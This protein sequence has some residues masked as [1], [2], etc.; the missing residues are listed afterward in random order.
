MDKNIVILGSTGS[1]GTQT[2]EVIDNL[3]NINVIALSTNERIDILETQIR[4]YKPK[5]AVVINK[6]KAN[7]L[8]ENI[9]DTSTKILVG[10]E[11][12]VFIS[13]IEEVHMMINALVGNVGL[14]PTVEAIKHKKDIALA[15]K[16]TLV[17]AGEIVMK[18][19]KK[20]DVNIYPIDSEHCAILQCIQGSNKNDIDKIIL[21][22]SGGP[23]RTYD[24]LLD[25][26]VEKALKH[27]NWIMG[28]KITIDSATLM[29]KGLEVIEA[30][31]LFDIDIENIDI[32]IHPQSIIHS[33]VQYKDNSIIAQLGVPDMRIPIQYCLTY[34]RKSKNN[35][36]KFDISKVLNLTFESPKYDLFP[37]LN[38]AFDAIKMGGT[39]PCVLNASNEIAVNKFLNGDIEFIEIPKIIKKCMDSHKNENNLIYT[40]DDVLK[41]DKW[42]RKYCKGI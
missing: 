2:L 9:K 1:I 39:M 32:V 7:I 35:L 19:V 36:E 17:S 6:I 23:F 10:E 11:N 12:L 15:N 29:N 31:W 8:K 37:C 25:I 33:M 3:N 41:F 5:F 18:L 40:L 28:K 38:L 34:P 30:K 14:I 21:T 22:A 13:I 20:Y 4:K 16:E 27:P 42:A 26:T 24:S